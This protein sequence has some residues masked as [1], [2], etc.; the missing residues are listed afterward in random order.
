[1]A[2]LEPGG[3][4]PRRRHGRPARGVDRRPRGQARQGRSRRQRAGR[5]PSTRPPSRPGSP[6]STRP[7]RPSTSSP[8]DRPRRVD[9][10]FPPWPPPSRRRVSRA[11]RAVEP[12]RRAAL[13]RFLQRTR[14]SANARRPRAARTT[15]S[16]RNTLDVASRCMSASSPRAQSSWPGPRPTSATPPRRTL[17]RSAASRPARSM[18]KISKPRCVTDSDLHLRRRPWPSSL[19]TGVVR[20]DS[21]ALSDRGS[22]SGCQITQLHDA[23]LP[24]KPLD[25][26]RPAPPPRS[27][28]CR[29]RA[30]MPPMAMMRGAKRPRSQLVRIGV[31]HRDVAVERRRHQMA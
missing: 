27:D 14:L 25:R 28:P 4:G 22:T 8:A 13:L 18:P 29:A 30:S 20:A 16:R 26:R 1:M 12:V 6:G 23:T 10:E 15:C 17:R 9:A 3:P 31:R 11:D 19:A 5:P 2:A 21:P 7:A 24:L